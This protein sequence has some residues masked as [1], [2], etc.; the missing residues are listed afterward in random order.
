MAELRTPDLCV[1][2]AGPAGIAAALAARAL[3]AEVVLVEAGRPG[4]GRISGSAMARALASLADRI[5]R[6]AEAEDAALR[7]EVSVDFAGLMRAVRERT[8]PLAR[9]LSTARLAAQGIEIIAGEASF[10]D[11]RRLRVGET[12]VRARRFIVATGSEPAPPPV[13]GLAD[14]GYLTE[15]SLFS[16]TERPAR[17]VVLGSGAI[18]L[19]LAQALARLGSAVTV[20]GAGPPLP[21]ADPEL[22]AILMRQLEAEG[23][24]QHWGAKIVGAESRGEEVALA[25]RMGEEQVTLSGTHVLVAGFRRPAVAGLG[26][27]RAGTRLARGERSGIAVG[28]TLRTSNP[29][30]Y[31]VGE[32]NGAE[33]SDALAEAQARLA[34]RHALL[35]ERIAGRLAIVPRVAFT[36]PAIAEIGTTEPLAAAER[37]GRYKVFRVSYGQ[38]DRA[39]FEE[40]LPG[41]VKL[42]TDPAGRILGAGLLGAEAP[43]LVAIVA[44][45]MDRG[46]PAH[47]LA[48]FVPPYPAHADLLRQ[49]GGQARGG[50]G[51]D[52]LAELRVRLGRFHP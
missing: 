15:E 44:F 2:G 11:R 52:R 25:L 36:D 10:A 18:A 8:R 9:D 4:G 41:L 20:V 30:V 21:G 22:V 19:E 34:V 28:P 23:I 46:V 51:V 14:L 39:R 47:A 43:E 3:G 26:L 40:R 33:P 42:V 37:A 31:A 50:E 29:R 16:L 32:V 6:I 24:A 35:G 5:R 7:S 48:H 12:T 17:L 13:P 45:A 1:V 38:S 27:E 49:L